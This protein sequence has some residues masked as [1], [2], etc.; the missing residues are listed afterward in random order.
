LLRGYPGDEYIDMVSI[1]WYGY[2]EDFN[3]AIDGPAFVMP[4][5]ATLASM[6]GFDPVAFERFRNRP[7]HEDMLKAMHEDPHYLFLKD[8]Q[9]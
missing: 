7:R 2:G 4:D 1:D 3:K 5:S 6:P 9:N 8:I